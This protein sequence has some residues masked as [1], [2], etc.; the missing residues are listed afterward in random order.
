VSTGSLGNGGMP[1][2][3][4]DKNQKKVV[5]AIKIKDGNGN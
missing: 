5:P 4:P 2:D 3:S 1:L